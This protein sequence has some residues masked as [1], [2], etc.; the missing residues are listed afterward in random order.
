MIKFARQILPLVIALILSL[1]AFTSTAS[2]IVHG[3]QRLQNYQLDYDSKIDPVLQSKLER[4]DS[5][6][7]T[8]YGMT[9][10]QTAVGVLDLKDMR[11]AMLHPD[12]EEYAASVAKLGILLA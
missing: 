2:E 6:L 7:R 4:I 10:A 5:D 8:K 12:R 3:P 11:L 1:A 9:P